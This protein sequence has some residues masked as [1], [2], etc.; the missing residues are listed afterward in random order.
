MFSA[1]GPGAI[2]SAGPTIV[3]GRDIN[4]NTFNV[5]P[6]RPWDPTGVDFEA[7]SEGMSAY[8][9]QAFAAKHQVEK[10]MYIHLKHKP[11]QNYA[12]Y[13]P[14][15]GLEQARFFDGTSYKKVEDPE[16]E[17]GKL[18]GTCFQGLD[19]YSLDPRS[20]ADIDFWCG[21]SDTNYDQ[22]RQLLS[23]APTKDD[24]SEIICAKLRSCAPA[25]K[26]FIEQ[27]NLVVEE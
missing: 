10:L 15:G 2:A 22:Q 27:H 4:S 6:V 21:L 5:Y 11:P 25:I 3:A 19:A 18:Y 9:A 13:L 12:V 17:L 24:R 8:L 14:E 20:R 7:L 23:R 16:R 1:T 26:E